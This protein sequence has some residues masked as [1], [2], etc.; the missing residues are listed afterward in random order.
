MSS[1]W[2]KEPPTVDGWYP[3]RMEGREPS[4]VRV[5]DHGKVMHVNGTG[6]F[7]AMP[8]SAYSGSDRLPG[9]WGPRIEFDAVGDP[10][11]VDLARVRELVAE[12][13]APYVSPNERGDLPHWWN[14]WAAGHNARIDAAIAALD[15]LG[16]GSP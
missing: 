9:E 3:F 6:M 12:L 4:I 7:G 16:K 8:L 2:R 1:P 13:R 14:E 11:P 15:A 5:S 10:P